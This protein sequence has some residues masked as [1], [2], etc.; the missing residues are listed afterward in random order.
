VARH[1]I[2]AAS[3]ING[4]IRPTSAAVRPE[5]AFLVA[6]RRQRDGPVVV[7]S[8][9]GPLTRSE[10]E[11][12]QAV[13][14]PLAL[15]DALPTAPVGLGQRWRVGDLAAQAISGY[16]VL[17]SNA[18]EATL[19]SVDGARARVR[20]KCRV[21]GSALGGTGLMTCEGSLTCDRRLGWIDHLVLN[22]AETRRPGP[23]EAGLDV[24]STLTVSRQSE[25]PPATLTDAGLAGLPLEITP[26]SQQ[27]LLIAP[28]GKSRLL[29][30]RHWH[31]FWDDPKL[32]VLKRL[33]GN[34]VAAQCHVTVGPSAGKGRHQDP[35]QFRDDIRRALRHRFVQFLGAGEIGGDPAGGFRYKV[36]VQGREADLGVVWYYYLVAG[37]AG[38]QLLVTFTLAEAYARAFGDQDT[39]MIRSLSW[40]PPS[41]ATN[42]R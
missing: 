33:E 41:G 35:T 5:V 10:L 18:L 26:R 39:E 30:D 3:A 42:H 14:D 8:P 1:V 7:V 11:L 20:I 38:D 28:D 27:L 36:G 24:Q 34:Q 15:A 2:Q 25:P 31:V 17:T 40:T 32:V 37:P 16:D 22:R 12:V 29:H 4:E 23:I 21:E 6:E 13:G 19:E 9:A